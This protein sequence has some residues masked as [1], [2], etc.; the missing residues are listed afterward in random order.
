MKAKDI[1]KLKAGEIYYLPSGTWN[2]KKVTFIRIIDEK[3]VLVCNK[4]NKTF[5]C[6]ISKLQKEPYKAVTGYKTRERVK[7]QMN[8]QKQKEQE[9]L[10]DKSIQKKVK[11]LGHSVYATMENDKYVVRGYEQ[12]VSFNTLEELDSWVD[13]ELIKFE[14]TKK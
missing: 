7:Q 2:Y 14:T 11:Q 6:N 9:S 1:N 3:H 10:V 4:K 13:V 12:T 5:S 8:E